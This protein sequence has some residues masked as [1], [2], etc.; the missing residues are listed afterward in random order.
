[1]RGKLVKAN[2]CLYVIRTL[3]AEGYNQCEIDYLFLKDP[4]NIYYNV[5]P[6]RLW[7]FSSRTQYSTTVFDRCFKRKYISQPVN[8]KHLFRNT[9]RNIFKASVNQKSAIVD[10][11][12]RKKSTSYSL[13]TEFS[14]YPRVNTEHFKLSFANRLIFNYNL[15]I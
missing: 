3:R 13:R 4:S 6:V 1:M 14:Q 15:F 8:I 7:F 12:P 5:W 10:L 2:K 9:D 11:I